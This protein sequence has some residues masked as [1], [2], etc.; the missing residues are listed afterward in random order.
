[1][2]KVFQHFSL[3]F[4]HQVRIDRVCGSKR[5]FSAVPARVR[6]RIAISVGLRAVGFCE[7]FLWVKP[8]TATPPS[9]HLDGRRSLGKAWEK[10]S[11]TWGVH[12]KEMSMVEISTSK[13]GVPQWSGDAASYQ[14][15]EEQALQ[16]EQSI[17]YGKRYLCGPK[18]IQEM[19]GTARKLV[20]GKPPDWLSF[21]GG[22]AHLMKHLRRS[23]GG[24][25]IPELSE[26]LNKHFKQS[27]R[28]KFETMNQ[29]IV[30]KTKVYQRAKQALARVLPHQR[31]SMSLKIS[32]TQLRNGRLIATAP[33]L[34]PTDGLV[35]KM[36]TGPMRHQSSCQVSSKDGISWWMPTSPALNATWFRLL[37]R[38]ALEMCELRR[39]FAHNG[40]RKT[41]RTM[42]KVSTSP[43]TG[44]TTAAE[45]SPGAGRTTTRAVEEC[46]VEGEID[47]I[48]AWINY[49]APD[50][51]A[52]SWWLGWLDSTMPWRR[53][54]PCR[55]VLRT[56]GWPSPGRRLWWSCRNM[57]CMEKIYVITQPD[58]QDPM[59]FG[60]HASRTYAEVN[61]AKTTAH[62]GQHS[63]LWSGSRWHPKNPRPSPATW[64]RMPRSRWRRWN[65]RWVPRKL[66]QARAHSVPPRPS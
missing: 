18:L 9:E 4:T 48:G 63:A 36:R 26:Y 60:N 8:A 61:W 7:L 19:S 30:R 40:Q 1:M 44:R 37:S 10:W 11:G 16:W 29:Y 5:S 15:Y 24:P 2:L 32:K 28:R 6:Y 56:W 51:K 54:R 14:E 25:Q 57:P 52:Q 21:N 46:R 3:M 42:T 50:T 47:G 41:W 12:G 53:R 59:G 33:R 55:S 27:R 45:C 39:S 49:D 62:E 17:A 23:L 13:D 22:V 64:A 65:R 43:A 66:L 35:T 38:E 58:G 20:T 34:S 31:R